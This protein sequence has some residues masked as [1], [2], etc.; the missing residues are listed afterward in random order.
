MRDKAVTIEAA[1]Q[2]Q[3]MKAERQATEIR[4]GRLS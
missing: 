4:I 3:N 2:T 1:G